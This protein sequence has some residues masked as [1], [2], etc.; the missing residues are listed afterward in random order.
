MKMMCFL[1]FDYMVLYV[2][3]VPLTLVNIFI[4]TIIFTCLSIHQPFGLYIRA[5]VLSPFTQDPNP[6]SPLLAL[7][8]AL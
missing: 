7:T 6:H 8:I 4:C 2:I 3:L 1:Y 5:S